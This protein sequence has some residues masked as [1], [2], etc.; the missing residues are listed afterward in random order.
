MGKHASLA[1]LIFGLLLSV[2][3]LT[4]LLLFSAPAAEADNL[5]VS[6]TLNQS[7]SFALSTG[8]ITLP[9]GNPGQ[10]VNSE[11]TPIDITVKTN[12]TGAWAVQINAATGNLTSTNGDTIPISALQ[13]K[14]NGGTGYAP[15]STTAASIVSATGPTALS[16]NIYQ[17]SFS[18]TYPWGKKPGT[19]SGQLVLTLS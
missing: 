10:T 1:R 9:A 2:S 7:S 5:T 19:Y 14:V 8:N 17:L 15:L 6:A 18:V 11:T 3:G 13:W 16:G 4:Y 12:N